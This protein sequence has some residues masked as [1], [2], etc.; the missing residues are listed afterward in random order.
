[1]KKYQIFVSS[2]YEDLIEQRKKIIENILDMGNIPAGME[3][4]NSSDREAF[5][6]IKK[7]IDD[8]DYL[9]LIIGECYGSINENTKV[10]YTEMEYDY[11]KENNIPILVFIKESTKTLKKRTKEAKS[12]LKFIKKAKDNRL[13]KFWQ[14]ETDL[15]TQIIHSIND[16]SIVNP[17]PGW[18]RKD[19]NIKQNLTV[20]DYITN[21]YRN[22]T[23]WYE[24]YKSGRIR[25]GGILTTIA[26]RSMKITLLYPYSDAFYSVYVQSIDNENIF[27]K[28]KKLTKSTIEFIIERGQG[29]TSPSHFSFIAEGF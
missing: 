6:Y 8:S 5:D 16:E 10:S 3:L 20:T 14:D 23:S 9:V 17:R 28:V 26:G 27:Y 7:I 12:L 4:F 2:T 13:V 25:Q 21:S 24:K 1:M 11:A 19:N 29:V 15:I 22:G 18:I